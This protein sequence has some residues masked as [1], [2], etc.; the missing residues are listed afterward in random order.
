MVLSVMLG[1]MI[2]AAWGP[3]LPAE[4][5]SAAEETTGQQPPDNLLQPEALLEGRHTFYVHCASCHGTE[6]WGGPCPNLADEV[7]LHGSR[8]ADMLATITRG[9]EGTEMPR[10]F[11]KL[12]FDRIMQVAA[13]VYSLKGTRIPKTTNGRQVDARRRA[14]MYTPPPPGEAAKP[15][16]PGPGE[17]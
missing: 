15:A 6:G 17:R 10:W 14:T 2:A 8:Y 1:V 13:Y 7:T 11:G 16:L 3:A 5:V 9:V 4:P 12:E